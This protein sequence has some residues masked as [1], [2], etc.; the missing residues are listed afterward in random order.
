ML[1]KI[2]EI[3]FKVGEMGRTV[4]F[5]FLR[6]RSFFI[7]QMMTN[8]HCWSAGHQFSSDSKSNS[9][10][11]QKNWGRCYVCMI[12]ICDIFTAFYAKVSSVFS[13]KLVLLLILG[14]NYLYSQSEIC[15][16]KNIFK[17]V[18]V[19]QDHSNTTYSYLTIQ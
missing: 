5:H 10:F 18:P 6:T 16:G 7:E 13:L 11:L 12:S 1:D 3:L 2:D 8:G 9:L 17:I 15:F 14:I 19:T 4:D